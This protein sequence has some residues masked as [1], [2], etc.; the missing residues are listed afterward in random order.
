MPMHGF[1]DN[2]IRIETEHNDELDNCLVT[3]RLGDFN[4]DGTALKASLL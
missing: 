3:V 1:T 4:E 2:Y